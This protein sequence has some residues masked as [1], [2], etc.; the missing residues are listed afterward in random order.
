[1]PVRIAANANGEILYSEGDIDQA[2]GIASLSKIWAAALIHDRM[3][4][5]ISGHKIS[6]HTL[7]DEPIAIEV[8]YETMVYERM[9]PRPDLQPPDDPLT[10]R[11]FRR[12]KVRFRLPV[13][14]G[15]SY[16]T[17]K[18]CEA[19]FFQSKN[20]AIQALADHFF[21]NDGNS[22]FRKA[23]YAYARRL[24]LTGTKI[25]DPHG[26]CDGDNVSTGRDLAVF[27]AA[28]IREGHMAFFG[29][30]DPAGKEHTAEPLFRDE[31]L[32]QNG[33]KILLAKT[34]SGNNRQGNDYAENLMTIAQRQNGQFQ[35]ALSLTDDDKF[36][37]VSDLLLMG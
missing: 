27:C 29:M 25:G 10:Y 1:M 33:V 34:A 19:S 35:I 12:E 21:A 11:P 13:E 37:T 28:L 14:K 5:A 23:S 31:R 3:K 30:F 36:N 6:L 15:K 2:Y 8:D 16:T 24:G 18:L 7:L 26:L 32:M 17:G 20:D 22:S 9:A 4:A